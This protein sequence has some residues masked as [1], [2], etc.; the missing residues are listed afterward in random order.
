MDW[1]LPTATCHIIRCDPTAH[2]L[3]LVCCSSDYDAHLLSSSGRPTLDDSHPTTTSTLGGDGSSQPSA[4]VDTQIGSQGI[5][6]QCQQALVSWIKD[7]G[8][9]ERIQS[10]RVV[11]H[12]AQAEDSSAIWHTAGRLWL[13]FK[14][15]FI[16]Q[17]EFMSAGLTP[18]HPDCFTVQHSICDTCAVLSTDPWA[19]TDQLH[20]C[21]RCDLT[22]CTDCAIL[23]DATWKEHWG[24]FRDRRG[25]L[26]CV[27]CSIELS[28]VCPITLRTKK[29]M[30]EQ[31]EEHCEQ[32]WRRELWGAMND[33]Q[34]VVFGTGPLALRRRAT[35]T[36]VLHAWESEA[37]GGTTYPVFA[38][39]PAG[40]VI[41]VSN[42]LS[43]NIMGKFSCKRIEGLRS[44]DSLQQSMVELDNETK[45]LM[46][47]LTLRGKLYISLS[48]S[49]ETMF[50]KNNFCIVPLQESASST[51][52][53]SS[54][55]RSSRRK[56]LNRIIRAPC[57]V[58]VESDVL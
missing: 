44:H 33:I 45:L 19:R 51:S 54:R 14:R 20:V 18:L 23:G 48:P 50:S 13:L 39:M 16:Y 32:L 21:D 9:R 30:R 57:N 1:V 52:S 35:M 56:V 17:C 8:I 27:A 4:P 55:A 10:W 3:A 47:Q 41:V 36:A 49:L 28:Q 26:L 24:T 25:T 15:G 5:S 58:H 12:L 38:D 11:T 7:V 40:N 37:K 34:D 42:N 53:T 43:G 2:S 29:E 46:H 22:I 6:K 31:E